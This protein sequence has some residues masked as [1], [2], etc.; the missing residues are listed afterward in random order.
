MLYPL[1]ERLH[2]LLVKKMKYVHNIPERK[3]LCSSNHLVEEYWK[4]VVIPSPSDDELNQIDHILELAIYDEE[5]N[6]LI[7]KIDQEL[8]LK[9]SK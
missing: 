9:Y 6:D 1:R 3:I 7:N 4:L 5:L 2:L 8:E